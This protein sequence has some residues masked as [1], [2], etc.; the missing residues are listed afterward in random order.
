[1]PSNRAGRSFP[2]TTLVRGNSKRTIWPGF[3]TRRSPLNLR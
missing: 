2:L 1:L 3:L